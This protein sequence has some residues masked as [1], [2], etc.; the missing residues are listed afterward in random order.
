MN[1]KF[2]TEAVYQLGNI[3]NEQFKDQP[4]GIVISPDYCKS[5]SN[6]GLYQFNIGLGPYAECY[7]DTKLL[8]I[9]TELPASMTLF[10]D[11]AFLYETD[12][13]IIID[14]IKLGDMDLFFIPMIPKPLEA[15]DFWSQ[16]NEA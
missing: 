6:G 12:D 1:F 4:I 9:D 10:V 16:K 8:K 3:K 7:E 14:Y 13:T 11:A 2:T 5:C 15:Y